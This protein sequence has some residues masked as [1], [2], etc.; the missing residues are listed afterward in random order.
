MP[1]RSAGWILALAALAILSLPWIAKADPVS[2]V[3]EGEAS[4]FTVYANDIPVWQGLPS[5]PIIGYAE[6]GC[7]ASMIYRKDVLLVFPGD[8][9]YVTATGPTGLES[10]PSNVRVQPLRHDS[11]GDGCVLADDF[12]DFRTEHNLIGCLPFP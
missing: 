12:N 11:T 3:H 2:W 5:A 7:T 4:A 1:R 8:V 6:E 9:V 10:G